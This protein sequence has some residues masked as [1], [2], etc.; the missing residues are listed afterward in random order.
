[1][2]G[3][4]QLSYFLSVIFLLLNVFDIPSKTVKEESVFYSTAYNV[5]PGTIEF[6]NNYTPQTKGILEEYINDTDTT[7]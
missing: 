6:L 2:V 1:M 7:R 5:I 4:V 3:V